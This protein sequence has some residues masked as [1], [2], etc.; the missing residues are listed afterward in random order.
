MDEERIGRLERVV[1]DLIQV[2]ASDARG[3]HE[4]HATLV[5]L[6]AQ[7]GSTVSA[8]S[9]EAHVVREAP[10]EH[11]FEERAEI[12]GELEAE[13]VEELQHHRP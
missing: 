8:S 6:R 12:A 2:L 3:R 1:G 11:L 4:L 13:F 9:A 7:L 10:D 5:G